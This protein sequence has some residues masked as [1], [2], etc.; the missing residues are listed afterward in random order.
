MKKEIAYFFTSLMFF[1]RIPCPKWI[2]HSEEKL[3]KATKYFPLIGIIVGSI[4]ALAYYL[5]QLVL[6]SS[7]SIILSMLTSILTTGAFHEDGLA[8]VCDG[9]GGGWTKE[10][11]LEIMKDS[12]IGTYGVVGLVLVLLSKYIL[13]FELLQISIGYFI[14]TLI[15]S[16]A[17]SRLN[18]TNVIL[19]FQ[20]AREDATSKSKPL[21]KKLDI[22]NYIVAVGIG[23][24]PLIAMAVIWNYCIMLIFIPLVIIAILLGRYFTKWIGG[25]TGDCLGTV[26]QMS[27]IIIYIFMLVIW[28]YI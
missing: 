23:I 7:I 15:S 20:Y 14:G 13:S 28:K 8:D 22:E 4:S 3:E 27:E 21:A 6:P 11:I 10:K 2:G 9:F 17:L 12:R 24:V 5:S 18:A 16:H 19:L 25:Y 26:Q 1:T